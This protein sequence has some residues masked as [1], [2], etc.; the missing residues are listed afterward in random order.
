MVILAAMQCDDLCHSQVLKIAPSH[1]EALTALAHLWL[2]V[3]RP[4]DA[5]NAA[6]QAANSASDDPSTHR[7]LAEC[8]R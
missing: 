4:R 2:T 3:S 6:R 7:L 1:K 5:V 8:L